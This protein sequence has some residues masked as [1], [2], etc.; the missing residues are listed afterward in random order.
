[1]AMHVANRLGV[2]VLLS[3]LLAGCGS[4]TSTGGDFAVPYRNPT[5]PLGVTSRYA[6]TG[7]AGKWHVRGAFPLDATLRT[8]E[9]RAAGLDAPVWV[10]THRKCVD[11]GACVDMAKIW[12]VEAD[13]AGADTLMDPTGGPDRR[14][15]VVW[16]D[17]AFRTAA[18]AGADG[19]FAWVLDRF[20]RGGTDRIAAARQ[21]LE[22][23]GFDLTDMQM[24]PK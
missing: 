22:F 24:R 23:S 8:V 13:V 6:D 18:V 11:G 16:V 2:F 1:M 4:Q 14:A 9:R 19:R 7:F 5:A 10:L 21:V 17:D 12:N 15:V 3:A 20:P